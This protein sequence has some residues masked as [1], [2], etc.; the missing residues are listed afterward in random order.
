VEA[1][2]SASVQ[3]SLGAHP[4]SYTKG[5]G[6]ITAVK[7]PEHGIEHPPASSTD[8]KESIELYLY[9]PS[10]PLWPVLG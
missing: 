1:R 6:S 7:W 3:T 4:A 2:Y 9:F 8:V 10:G 5:T